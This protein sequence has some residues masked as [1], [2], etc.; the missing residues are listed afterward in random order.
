MYRLSQQSRFK[1]SFHKTIVFFELYATFYYS[2]RLA[3]EIMKNQTSGD[4]VDKLVRKMKL[5]TLF[6]NESGEVIQSIFVELE[7][8]FS[9]SF[10]DKQNKPV[11]QQI[12]RQCYNAP[13]K[14][15]YKVLYRMLLDDNE[16]LI[17]SDKK[18]SDFKEFFFDLLSIIL[19]DYSLL[20]LKKEGEQLVIKKES[21]KIDTYRY[22]KIYKVATIDSLM[23]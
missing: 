18:M 19:L 4:F 13:H 9:G 20:G 1:F 22:Q 14:V 8:I 5:G 15:F 21:D 3:F 6:K 23:R 17:E 16:D 11:V 10:L 7:E 2:K 12:I